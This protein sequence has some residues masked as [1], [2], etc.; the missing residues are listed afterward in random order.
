M[1]K[2]HD[3]PAKGVYPVKRAPLFL[4]AV[5]NA[6]NGKNDVLDQLNDQPTR[7]EAISV[8]RRVGP[9]GVASVNL[10]RKGCHIYATGEYIHLADVDGGSLRE[11]EAWREWC[12]AQLEGAI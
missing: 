8:Y 11:T 7:A 12:T 2:L 4:R 10:G 9:A 3:G 1:I 5:V 6:H